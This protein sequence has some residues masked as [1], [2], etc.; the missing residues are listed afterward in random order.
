LALFAANLHGP[1]TQAPETQSSNLPQVTGD[2]LCRFGVSVVRSQRCAGGRKSAPRWSCQTAGSRTPRVVAA[3][4]AG[5]RTL[6]GRRFPTPACRRK[7]PKSRRNSSPPYPPSP[8]GRG[9]RPEAADLPP[10]YPS[11]LSHPAAPPLTTDYCFPTANH[12]KDANKRG[13]MNRRNVI[14][15]SVATRQSEPGTDN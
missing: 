5:G 6:I 9:L 13:K 15:R 1:G 10:S 12:A 8:A 2:C 4:S 14:A 7:K 11:P 3:A